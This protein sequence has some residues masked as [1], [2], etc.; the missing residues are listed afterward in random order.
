MD[1]WSHCLFWFLISKYS[2]VMYSLPP[3]SLSWKPQEDKMDFYNKAKKVLNS[4]KFANIQN[5]D[6]VFDELSLLLC[7]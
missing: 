4:S 2:A 6:N 3:E 5:A 7:W 1:R